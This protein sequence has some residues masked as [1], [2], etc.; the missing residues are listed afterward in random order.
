MESEKK[1]NIRNILEKGQLQYVQKKNRDAKGASVQ[2]E[3]CG[4]AIQ[5]MAM[6]LQMEGC[7]K[8]PGRLLL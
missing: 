6:K 3:V 1:D 5:I 2:E 4:K 7:C 8:R